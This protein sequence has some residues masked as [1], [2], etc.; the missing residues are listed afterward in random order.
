MGDAYLRSGGSDSVCGQLGQGEEPFVHARHGDYSPHLQRAGKLGW[1]NFHVV[2][3]GGKGGGGIGRRRW[4]GRVNE[5][6]GMEGR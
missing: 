4:E 3:G 1:T 5:R 6:P 2:S